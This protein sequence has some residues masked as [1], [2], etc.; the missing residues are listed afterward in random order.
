MK[1]L[2]DS[3]G[4]E[5]LIYSSLQ[6]QRSYS[7]RG[8]EIK[9]LAIAMKNSKSSTTTRRR[10]RKYIIQKEENLEFMVV[11]ENGKMI[12]TL[13]LQLR[14]KDKK[15]MVLKGQSPLIQSIVIIL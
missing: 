12:L 15:F 11:R 14:I 5:K 9:F 6:V 8:S 3:K 1:K 10:L 4:N 2:K 7:A 13:L